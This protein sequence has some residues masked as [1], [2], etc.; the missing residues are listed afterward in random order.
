M[1]LD[2]KRERSMKRKHLAHLVTLLVAV[3]MV[4]IAVPASATPGSGAVVTTLARGLAVDKVKTRGNQPYDVVVQHITIAPGGHTG[5]HTH[6]G[7]VIVVVKSGTLT[8]YEGDDRSCTGKDFAAGQ[9]YLDRGYGHVH[10]GRNESTTAVELFVTFLD[11]P[12]GG[13]QRIDAA[14]PGNCPF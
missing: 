6:P 4:M 14:A 1:L 13:A 10:I 11:V 5:W 3:G 8:I 9:V 12:V 7:N 2:G